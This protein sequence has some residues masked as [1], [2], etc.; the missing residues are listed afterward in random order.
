MSERKPRRKPQTLPPEPEPIRGETMES[1]AK[2][3][4]AA[5]AKKDWRYQNKQ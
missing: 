3:V 4:F 1:F 5:P 2:A